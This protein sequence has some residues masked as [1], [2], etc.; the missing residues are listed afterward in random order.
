LL[1]NAKYSKTCTQEEH[2][3]LDEDEEDDEGE[4][5]EEEAEEEELR[6]IGQEAILHTNCGP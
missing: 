4:G 6:Y 2:E 3:A 1:L 5:T